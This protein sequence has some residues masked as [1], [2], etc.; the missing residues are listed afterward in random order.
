MLF[1][2]PFDFDRSFQED[3]SFF[4]IGFLSSIHFWNGKYVSREEVISLRHGLDDLS[5]YWTY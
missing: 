4:P 2:Y 1:E 3:G 5:N